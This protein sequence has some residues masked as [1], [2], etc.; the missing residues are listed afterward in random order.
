MLKRVFFI[1]L[2][3]AMPLMAA[4]EGWEQGSMESPHSFSLSKEMGFKDCD[5]TCP[6]VGATGPTGPAGPAGDPGITGATGPAGARGPTGLTGATGPAGP[7]G[8]TGVTGAPG[9]RGVTG[10]TGVTGATGAIGN[11]GL[12]GATGPTGATG[13]IGATGSTGAIGPTGP[14]GP[15][16][17]AGATG[18]TGL[19][20]AT[21]P[22]GV[23]LALPLSY[24]S[25]ST[26]N[27]EPLP[28]GTPPY[29]S[30]LDYFINEYDAANFTIITSPAGPA[31]N[32]VRFLSAGTYRV[33][34]QVSVQFGGEVV[35]T[36]LS[37][38]C[39][40]T[41]NGQAIPG[42][43]VAGSWW[44][45]DYNVGTVLGDLFPVYTNCVDVI[46]TFAANDVMNVVL[47]TNSSGIDTQG[48]EFDVQ[49]WTTV[50]LTI[51]KLSN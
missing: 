45:G 8:P 41:V 15:T 20:G 27:S 30:P 13:I 5:S 12:T 4:S 39:A 36:D 22:T 31:V 49:A 24:F 11:N 29:V 1:F 7:I 10:V 46:S 47:F 38:L 28:T 21:G 14:T 26:F 16:G 37:Y 35:N 44:G 50:T 19:G 42:N 51:I 32:A 9:P 6:V 3:G 33:S 17:P 2:Y 43:V 40:L 25:A 34:Y 23:G 18:I 48:I